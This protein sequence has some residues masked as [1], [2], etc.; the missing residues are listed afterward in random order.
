MDDAKEHPPP[1]ANRGRASKETSEN[2]VPSL[3]QLHDRRQHG[4]RRAFDA[5]LERDCDRFPLNRR[6]SGVRHRR[7]LPPSVWPASVAL[8]LA[9]NA[10]Q[11][12]LS[13]VDKQ[14]DL[15][16]RNDGTA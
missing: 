4:A 11:Q 3:P 5:A 16:E 14:L 8:A 10:I 13:S 7:G 12:Q 9:N 6:S 1:A 15:K 2:R